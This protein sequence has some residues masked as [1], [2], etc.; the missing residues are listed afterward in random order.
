MAAQRN[1]FSESTGRALLRGMRNDS[2]A[3]Y[4]QQRK[5]DEAPAPIPKDKLCPEALRAWD[6]FGYFRRRYFGRISTP[7]QEEAGYKVEQ[8]ISTPQ[9]EYV[10]VS[11]PPGSGKSTLFTL[12]IAAWLTVRNRAIRGMIGSASQSLAERYVAQLRIVLETTE[13]IPP[14]DEELHQGL[15]VAPEGVLCRDY[16]YFRVTGAMGGK[17]AADGFVVAQHDNR[18]LTH[19]EPTWSAYGLDSKYIG[20]RYDACFWDDITEEAD[21][22]TVERIEKQRNRYDKVAEKR[23]EP[24][25]TIVMPGQRLGP[26]DLYRYNL[27]KPAGESVAHDHPCCSAEPGKKY[28]HIVYPAHDDSRCTGDHG[29]DAKY[30]PEGCL[31]D[32]K[33]LPWHELEAEMGNDL[34]TYLTVFQQADADPASLL[35]HPMWLTGGTDPSTRISYPGCWDTERSF[36]EI[37]K[38]TDELIVYATTDPSPTQYWANQVWAFDPSSDFRFLL[39]LEGRKMSLPEFLS[40]NNGVFTGLMEEWWQRS[41]DLKKPIRWW[42]IEQNAAQRFI[43]QLDSLKRW[44]SKRGVEVVAHQTTNNKSDPKY[45]PQMLGDL[46]RFGKKR[47]PGFGADRAR[48]QKLCDELTKWPKGR[49]D[50]QVMADWFGEYNRPNFSASTKSPK[51]WLPSW[52]RQSA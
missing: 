46:Y 13:L 29:P 2:G 28:H 43:L 31:L 14:E 48:S 19:K 18:I 33:R 41:C 6:D 17:W 42:I 16:G 26:E 47:L 36:W 34:G 8:F 39:A 20:G 9:K 10:I 32:P 22:Y 3:D 7:W 30:Q 44:A 25:G 40:E 21:T 51:M 35:V 15:A 24:A 12:D 52:M 23:L 4:R 1:G 49:R 45:G 27:D 38:G 5:V 37:P 11:C 50:D